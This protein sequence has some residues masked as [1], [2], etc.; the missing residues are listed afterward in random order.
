MSGAKVNIVDI[1]PGMSESVVE[2]SG[3]P[4][5]T[6]TAQSL[7]QNFIMGGQTSSLGYGV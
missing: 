7:L 5:Q 4:E 2:I 3:T 6:H 1:R